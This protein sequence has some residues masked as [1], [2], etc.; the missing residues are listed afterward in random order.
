MAHDQRHRRALTRCGFEHAA[1]GLVVSG[2]NGDVLVANQAACRMLGHTEADL[3]QLDMLAVTHPDDRSVDVAGLQA[4]LAGEV[5]SFSV[6]K[7]YLNR[8]G[9]TV[10]TCQTVSLV[11]G[12]NARPSVFV[13]QLRDITAQKSTERDNDAFFHLSPDM[14]AVASPDI[15]HLERMNP[16]WQRIL[17]WTSE[18]LA[19]RPYTDFLHPQDRPRAAELAPELA[20][21][22]TSRR[23]RNRFMSKQG[24]YRYLEWNTHSNGD[25]RYC[26]VRDMTRQQEIELKLKLLN[27][28]LVEQDLQMSSV[29]D[30][31]GDGLITFDRS[32]TVHA[33]N[34][35]A[36]RMFGYSAQQIIGNSVDTLIPE[37]L[38]GAQRAEIDAHLSGESQLVGKGMAVVRALRKDG[39]V[40]QAE[41][42]INA[43]ETAHGELFVAVLRDVTERRKAEFELFSEKERLRVTLNSI[44]DAVI[45]TDT[46]SAVTYLNPVAEQMTGWSNEEALGV[47][48]SLVMV[49][50]EEGTRETAPNPIDTVLREGRVVGLA[51]NSILERRGGG[52]FAIEDSAS[53]I[54]HANNEII[55]T[56]LVF[57]DVSEARRIAAEMTHQA[58]HDPLTDLL[59][60]R[61]FERKLDSVLKQTGNG[62][63]QTSVLFM[64]LDR[65]KVV[66]DTGGHAAGDELLRQLAS[67]FR[68]R[69]RNADTLA[70]LGGD[71]FG[72]ILADCKPDAALRIAESLRQAIAHFPFVWEDHTFHVGVSIGMVSI[73]EGSASRE[74]VLL[75]ADAACYLAKDRGRNRIHVYR[76]D[77]NH[78]ILQHGEMGWIARIHEALQENRFRLCRQTSVALTSDESPHF[79]ILL[80][81]LEPDG[82]LV[83]PMTFIPAAER[84]GLMLEID[85][86]VINAALTKLGNHP[87]QSMCFINLS[88][89]SIGDETLTDYVKSQV[90][91]TGVCTAGLCFEITETAAIANLKKADAVIMEIKKLGCRFALDDFGSGM[92][93]FAYLKHLPVDYLKIDGA[94]VRH[95]D[96]DPIDR[97]MVEAI[98][99][100]GH[101]MGIE[102]IAEYVENQATVE[103]LADMGVNYAQGYWIEKPQL[104]A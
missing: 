11:R 34:A 24:L 49:L 41:L 27:Q 73:E 83:L 6:E 36:S 31:I 78:R 26:V 22:G 68:R 19:G 42:V 66:N 16:A 87:D 47:D 79:E 88:A 98:N 95:M 85:R 90:E 75:Q 97:A 7:R 93:S 54:R 58:S 15:S 50:T 64:D 10:Q 103:M 33:F 67:T 30:N 8:L 74:E 17:G 65:F 61:G 100:I 60:R 18:E 2:L 77:D 48:L 84:Y 59:N 62:H 14:V 43:I 25:H 63:G 76:S 13:S 86:W 46:S 71:E 37:D 96:K 12:A 70:R 69:L 40:F 39:G 35:A 53:P 104:W 5:E 57:H 92:S 4:L 56:V 21:N 72:V 23:F 55:G 82:R 102:T 38:R 20:R 44:G 81:M 9:E 45:T 51:E 99:N 94:F 89:A 91:L 101:V 32:G 3:L 29:V 1:S 28:R 80:R 52:R